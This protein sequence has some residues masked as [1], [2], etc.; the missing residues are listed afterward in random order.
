MIRYGGFLI[1]RLAGSPGVLAQV[2]GTHPDG[3]SVIDRRKSQSAIFQFPSIQPDDIMAD[4][5]VCQENPILCDE[6]ASHG[7]PRRIL[8]DDSKD[9]FA[10]IDFPL[11][12]FRRPVRTSQAVNEW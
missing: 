9:S 11:P 1:R 12:S 3:A 8:V 5:I 2:G 4:G 6:I 10:E 7:P